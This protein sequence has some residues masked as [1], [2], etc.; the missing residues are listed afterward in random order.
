MSKKP[1]QLSPEELG[2]LA[3]KLCVATDQKEADRLTKEIMEG[4]YGRRMRPEDL[5]HEPRSREEIER[6]EQE[7]IA[8]IKSGEAKE[9]KWT[10]PPNKKI[11]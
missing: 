4:F 2:I 7:W 1:K 5:H 3:K 10:P 6:E 8:K 11:P 9:V